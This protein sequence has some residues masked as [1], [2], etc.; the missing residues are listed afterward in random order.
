M[1]SYLSYSADSPLD[2]VIYIWNT[3]S[4]RAQRYA[5]LLTSWKIIYDPHATYLPVA[6]E[7]IINTNRSIAQLDMR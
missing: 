5:V 1:L 3:H 2:W 7:Q 6:G 4:V